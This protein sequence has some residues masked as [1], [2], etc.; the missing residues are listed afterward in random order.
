MANNDIVVLQEQLDGSL[1][2]TLLSSTLIQAQS[3]VIV[4]DVS[5]DV[6]NLSD[7][8]VWIRK[9]DLQQFFLYN[10]GDTR[11]W[12]QLPP[13]PH[14]H[15]EIPLTGFGSMSTQNKENVNITGGTISG[16]VTIDCG[17]F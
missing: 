13:P 7:N 10:D 6:S 5:P 4:S 9:T 12:I 11:Q 14:T 17:E 2:E 3:K 16:S 15:P 1:K 8:Q